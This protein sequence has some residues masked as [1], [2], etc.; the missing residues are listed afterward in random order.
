MVLVDN[1]SKFV[2]LGALKDRKSDTLADWF[3]RSVVAYFGVPAV[4]KSDGG[5]EFTKD[6]DKMCERLGV[7]HWVTLPHHPQ[8]NG[9]AERFVKTTK[10]YLIRS[11]VQSKQGIW[12]D[13]L[14]TVQQTI[15]TTFATAHGHT[16]FHL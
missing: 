3:Y 12:E 7:Q 15:N 4:V 9:I 8:S 16:P 13:I 11:L 2:V 14:P 6:F 10:A 1:F 5:S